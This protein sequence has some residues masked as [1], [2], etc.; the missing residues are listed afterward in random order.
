MFRLIPER[1]VLLFGSGAENIQSAIRESKIGDTKKY[2]L[3]GNM[4][5]PSVAQL[6]ASGITEG[7]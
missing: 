6:V 1:A 5:A 4:V 2:V 7:E 3:L